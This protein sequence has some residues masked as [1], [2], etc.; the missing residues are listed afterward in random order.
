MGNQEQAL[1]GLAPEVEGEHLHALAGQRIEGAERFVEQQ[2]IRLH[3]QRASQSQTLPLTAGKLGD[4]VVG[5]LL[6]SDQLQHFMR[7]RLALGFTQTT[8][9]QSEGDVF[10]SAQPRHQRVVL[11]HHATFAT[12]TFEDAAIDLH[13]AAVRRLE[14][15]QH[16]EQAGLAA[17]GRPEHH[18]RLALGQAQVQ[19]AQHLAGAAVLL[20]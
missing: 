12:R 11:E 7:T 10:Q 16:V 2:E 9:A 14:P 20:E 6:Q 15:G 17:A 8:N 1:A 3:R 5:V 13:A 18:Q 19:V 4:A